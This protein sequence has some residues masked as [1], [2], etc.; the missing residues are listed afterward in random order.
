MAASRSRPSP[1]LVERVGATLA[2]LVEPHDVLTVGLSGGLDSTVLLHVLA[3]LAPVQRF[4]LRAAHVHHGLQAAA[5]AWPAHCETVCAKL[6]VPLQVLRVEVDRQHPQGIEAAA[7]AARHAALRGLGGDWLALAHHRGDQAETLLH[8]L[9]RGSGVQ[10]AAG[11]RIADE[12][13]GPPA[14]LRPLLDEP[15]NE[16]EDWARAQQLDWIEDPSNADTAYSRNFLR[17]DI[18]EPLNRR[19]PGAEAALAR[20]A[21]HFL[22]ATELLAALARSDL[23]VVR[24]G[25]RASRTA[26]LALDD[27]RL[28]NLL[29][30]R[31]AARDLPA[32]DARQLVEAIRQ[33]RDAQAPWRA[34]FDNWALCVQDDDVWI[35]PADLPAAPGVV[36][37]RGEP[38]L[39]WGVARLR[40]PARMDGAAIELRPRA[41]G[42]HI[43]PDP[44]RPSRDLKTLAREQGAPP[45]W[46]EAIPVIWQDGRPIWFAGAAQTGSDSERIEWVPRIRAEF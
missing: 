6:G 44:R 31:L 10:G 14:L 37:W 40:F 20:A 35:E 33:L 11:M 4:V 41:G 3:R 23:A 36:I 24:R 16:L 28:A 1:D 30:E 34:R 15:R 21:G 17:H 45:W 7:R 18:L 22:E 32:P 29:R 25:T 13:G 38:E 5:D 19:F 46:R 26:L 9:T 43:R 39:D 2:R 27:A 12:R 42:E 8:R